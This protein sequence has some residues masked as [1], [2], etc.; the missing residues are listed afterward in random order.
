MKTARKTKTKETDANR[1]GKPVKCQSR[2][3][4][5]DRI[6]AKQSRGAETR[7]ELLSDPLSAGR[8]YRKRDAHEYRNE[9]ARFREVVPEGP[10]DQPTGAGG[11]S[12]STALTYNTGERKPNSAIRH[13]ASHFR[14]HRAHC[15]TSVIKDERCLTAGE[16]EKTEQRADYQKVALVKAI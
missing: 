6:S 3:T 4:Y 14:I 15:I 9:R 10:V 12:W 2:G 16:K 13:E 8:L 5:P 7:N 1:T 11:T